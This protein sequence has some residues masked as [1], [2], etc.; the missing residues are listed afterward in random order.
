MF[1]FADYTVWSPA[2][3]VM[4]KQNC[5]YCEREGELN[6]KSFRLFP[7]W[8]S[9]VV[10]ALLHLRNIV[11]WLVKKQHNSESTANISTFTYVFVK[12]YMELQDILH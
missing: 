2:F 1:E 7:V 12:D 10:Q 11:L 5:Y 9:S 3:V 8:P 6:F 4:N